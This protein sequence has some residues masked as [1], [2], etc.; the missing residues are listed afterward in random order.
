M[1]NRFGT[2][3][4]PKG[5]FSIILPLGFLVIILVLFNMGI[6]YL[7]QANEQEALESAR[8]AIL[9]STIHFYA[10]EGFYPP[11]IDVLVERYGLLLDDERFIFHYNAFASNIMPNI[12]VLP[13]DY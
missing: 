5:V 9:R 1:G 2:G 7:V 10:V 13:R 8:N 3:R 12:V 11:N 4:R 6:N